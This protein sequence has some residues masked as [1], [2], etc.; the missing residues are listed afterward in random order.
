MQ[1]KPNLN[2]T[3]CEVFW[4]FLSIWFKTYLC[5]FWS[6]LHCNILRYCSNFV[7]SAKV[8]SRSHSDYFCT[9]CL[10]LAV[11][12]WQFIIKIVYVWKRVNRTGKGRCHFGPTISNTPAKKVC[13]CNLHAYLYNIDFAMVF[14]ISSPPVRP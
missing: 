13:I 12:R 6:H 8:V 2:A 7:S 10:C 1:S 14:G 4:P 5:V 11:R 3:S 9:F